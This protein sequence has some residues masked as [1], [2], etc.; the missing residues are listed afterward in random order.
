MQTRYGEQEGAEVGYNPVKR[1]RPSHHP[2]VAV[3]AGTRL[4]VYYRWRAGDSH[5][6]G[7]WKEAMEECLEWLGPAHCPWLNR[8]DIGFGGRT[9]AGVA[10][11]G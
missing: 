9:N 11:S 5:T 6:A 4:C 7:E 3:A 2:L 10:R 1:G 8:G